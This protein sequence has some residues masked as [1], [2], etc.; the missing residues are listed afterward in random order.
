M[1][2]KFKEQGNFLPICSQERNKIRKILDFRYLNHLN[3]K[4]G[5][6]E[7]SNVKNFSCGGVPIAMN[8][9]QVSFLCSQLTEMCSKSRNN[10]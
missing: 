1:A 5:N 7:R 4:S 3:E 2:R 6:S 9:R 10:F 8:W